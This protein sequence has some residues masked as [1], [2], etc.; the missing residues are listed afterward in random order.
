MSFYWDL[1]VVCSIS[2]K[3]AISFI[4]ISLVKGEFR[5]A[6]AFIEAIIVTGNLTKIFTNNKGNEI[7]LN[8]DE[9]VSFS[10][11]FVRSGII[12]GNKF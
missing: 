8:I 3:L 6:F 10:V 11:R 1:F 9:N 4:S 7:N 12:K 2:S 5:K